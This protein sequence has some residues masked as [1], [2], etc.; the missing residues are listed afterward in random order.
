MI[1][2]ILLNYLF[3]HWSFDSDWILFKILLP[4]QYPLMWYISYK[5][6]Q[7]YALERKWERLIQLQV[8]VIL[9]ETLYV[10]FICSLSQKH[11]YE[12]FFIYSIILISSVREGVNKKR[13][14]LRGWILK[15]I[16][17]KLLII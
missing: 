7:K 4:L 11:F 14:K 2:V 12:N 9:S 15:Q 6:V 1:S 3:P 10:Y 8:K 17:I 5:I 13:I 16:K